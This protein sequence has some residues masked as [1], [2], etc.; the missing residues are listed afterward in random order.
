MLRTN[1][2]DEDKKIF[3]NNSPKSVS[4]RLPARHLRSGLLLKWLYYLCVNLELIGVVKNRTEPEAQR[5]GR[6]RFRSFYN[7]S[8]CF[9]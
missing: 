8:Y 3:K 6:L 1:Y 4:T 5:T 2:T 7:L 9:L